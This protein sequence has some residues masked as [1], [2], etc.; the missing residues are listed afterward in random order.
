MAK[1][2]GQ[3]SIRW[4]NIRGPYYLSALSKEYQGRTGE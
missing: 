1:L 4:A 2:H 3:V